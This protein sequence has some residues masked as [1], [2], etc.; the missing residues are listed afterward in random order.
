MKHEELMARTFELAKRGLGTTWPNPLV[1]A[2]I[3]KDGKIISEGHH[4]FHGGP[5]AEIAAIN[6]AT[7]SLTGATIYVN[8]EPC[9]HTNK[10]T[11]PCA[12]KLI[13]KGFK[14][15]I[16][17]NL[18]PNP[19]V[20]GQGLELLRSHGIE[21]SHGILKAEGEMLNEVFFT[22]QRLKRPF[23]HLKSATTLDGKISLPDG[24]SQ[25]ITG[26]EAR[27]D[28]HRLRSLHQGIM[29][30]GETLRKDNPRLTVRVPEYQGKQPWRIVLSKSGN[31]PA[32][33][34]LFT[35]E[36]R[37]LT[38][39]YTEKDLAFD[40]PQSQVIKIQSLQDALDDLFQRKIINILA[41]FG[42][43]LATTFLNLGLIDRISLYQ[44]P[45]FLGEGRGIFEGLN[46]KN[47]NQ[48]FRLTHLES[49]WVGEDLYL[50]GRIR[51]SQD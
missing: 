18:D 37:H 12:Q 49:K 24:E 22:A 34:T 7:E 42:T 47:L 33:H 44:N 26:Q 41:E 19:N 32:D 50:T 23:I 43:T 14:K 38:L 36:F 30:G 45:S 35:D 39:V 21:V 17:C 6:N 5:H 9:C 40:F 51:C 15:V 4:Q 46:V 11:H 27:L 10:L 3:V 13:E 29:I 25:W 28:V 48:R 8:L 2:V 16:V 1:G 20:N 31:L